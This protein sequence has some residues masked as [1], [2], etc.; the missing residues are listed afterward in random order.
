MRRTRWPGPFGATITTSTPAGGT[1]RPKGTGQRIEVP[2]TSTIDG[3]STRPAYP[4]RLLGL[5]LDLSPPTN[6]VVRGSVELAGLSQ[7]EVES[8]EDWTPIGFDPGAT[9]WTWSRT[10]PEGTTVYRPPAGSP[11]R[12]EAGLGDEASPAIFGSPDQP[13]AIY[14]L[15]TSPNGDDILPAIAGDRLLALTGARVGDTIAVTSEAHPLT[16]R[17]VGSTASFPPLDPESAFLVVD[18]ATLDLL[19]FSATNYPVAANEWWLGLDPAGA[20]AA[21]ATLRTAPYSAAEVIQRDELSRALADDPVWLGVV[22]VLALGAVAAIVFA[23]IGFIVSAT[24]TTDERLGELA[25]LRALGLSQR[26]LSTWLTVEQLFLLAVGLIGG[27]ALGLLLAWL[28]LPYSTLSATG[29]AVIPAPVIVV[30]WASIL[31]VYAVTV[32]ILVGAV[33][34]LARRMPEAL[35]SR[36]L[37]AGG[38]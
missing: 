18:G 36:V 22:G 32:A 14:R 3:L 35:V 30:P 8:G 15:T 4:L 34:I 31:P 10:G 5:E 37:R 33:L 20:K 16:V 6:L 1:I 9:G 7:S 25:L 17:I 12:I 28:V 23:G 27:S 13:G 21:V 29:A 11:G 2:L 19:S 24:V 26:Q 38:E